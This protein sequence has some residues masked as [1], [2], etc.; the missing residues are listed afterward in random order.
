MGCALKNTDDIYLSVLFTAFEVL[1]NAGDNMSFKYWTSELLPEE[2]AYRYVCI[3]H[4]PGFWDHVLVGA[5]PPPETEKM[6][7]HDDFLPKLF[8]VCLGPYK[9]HWCC[10][11]FRTQVILAMW[12]TVSMGEHPKPKVCPVVVNE[13]KT[14]TTCIEFRRMVFYLAK[15]F[16]VQ[17]DIGAHRRLKVV[18]DCKPSEG[19]LVHIVTLLASKSGMDRVIPTHQQR[20]QTDMN[21]TFNRKNA[22][23]LFTISPAVG[24]VSLINIVEEFA[25]HNNADMTRGHM[26]EYTQTETFSFM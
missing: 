8:N 7:A 22:A 2:V 9:F 18:L 10:F 17:Y 19:S 26:R 14:Y 24:S 25:S 4:M 13:M 20:H 1:I 12:C 6:I 16:T 21:Y 23:D 5:R 3:P 11:V 15:W